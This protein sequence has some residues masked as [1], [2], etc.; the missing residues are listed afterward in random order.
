MFMVLNN[1]FMTDHKEICVQTT[2]LITVTKDVRTLHCASQGR[3]V[4]HTKYS[5]YDDTNDSK[6]ARSDCFWFTDPRNL[7]WGC[8]GLPLVPLY[9]NGDTISCNFVFIEEEN[10][11]TIWAS[12]NLGYLN[13]GMTLYE[14]QK[15]SAIKVQYFWIGL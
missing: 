10:L 9:C 1:Q 15:L 13:F 12:K 6:I 8:R 7:D 2:S 5:R 11:R 4:V 14:M 3:R